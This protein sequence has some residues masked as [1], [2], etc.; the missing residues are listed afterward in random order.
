M[1]ELSLNALLLHTIS[2]EAKDTQKHLIAG[3]DIR[4]S[5]AL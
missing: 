5:H 2:T 3:S 1:R 4:K